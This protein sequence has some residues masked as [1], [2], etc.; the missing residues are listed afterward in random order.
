[1]KRGE[2]CKY[3]LLA[4]LTGF[5]FIV[6]LSCAQSDVCSSSIRTS[7]SLHLF[8]NSVTIVHNFLCISLLLALLAFTY[9]KVVMGSLAYTTNLSV[10]CAH[11]GKTDTDKSAPVVTQLN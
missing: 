9:W 1:M 11:K 5:L 2:D 8:L 4:L 7:H 3:P 10:C 6:D